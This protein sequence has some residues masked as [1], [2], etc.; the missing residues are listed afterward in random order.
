MKRALSVLLILLSL[1]LSASFEEYFY[2]K[3]L[4]ID[5]FRTGDSVTELISINALIE[6]PHWGGSR[7]NLIDT[8]GLGNHKFELYH[9][10]SEELIYSRAH[11]S[12]FFEW[13]TTQEAKTTRRTFSETIIM[14]FPKERALVV[15]YS[16]TWKGEW[17]KTFEY[18]IDPESIFI[19]REQ[20]ELWP[21]FEVHIS[22]NP[23]NAV[24]FVFLPEGY[25][26]N[27]MDKFRND[28]LRF[29]G[30]LLNASPFKQNIDR[31]N[32]RAVL[33][34]SGES[35]TDIPGQDIWRRTIMNSHF[36]TFA[37][38]RYLTTS[39]MKSVRNVAANVP[40]DQIVI[41]VNSDK[42]GGGGIYNYYA[43]TTADH[44]LSDFVFIHEIGHS[45][46]GLGDEYYTKDVT[47]QNFYD[48][49]SEPWEP[50][51]T[52][53]VDF[54]RKW[55]DMLK[56]ETPVPTP[57]TEE[58]KTMIGVFEGGGYTSTGMFRPF[59]DCTMK[60]ASFDNF[61][62]V[63]KRAIERKIRFASE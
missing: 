62:P 31:I 63:C 55:K 46:A 37:L 27:E 29:A 34:P 15:F 11:S 42:Y 23:W 40:Y 18:Q 43:I 26:E 24:D 8:L 35:G 4:R 58:F 44:L 22:A 54:D 14:P 20:N 51:L 33:A 53:L 9:L 16:R 21:V 56:P 28:C 48:L 12:L 2:P 47:Y 61:C 50:N 30:Y 39:D 32:I 41:L 17:V 57:A 36:Y 45:F 59:Y 7:I 38:E 60:S 6:E 25:T 1:Q 13:Q 5:Y 52:T 3:T 10:F 19:S 49:E